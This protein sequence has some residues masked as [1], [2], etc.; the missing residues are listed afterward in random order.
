MHG[1]FKSY[2]QTRQTSEF[3]PQRQRIFYW[4]LNRI[5]TVWKISFN[6][7]TW[8]TCR[9]RPRNEPRKDGT[10]NI[11]LATKVKASIVAIRY[12]S[13]VALWILEDYSWNMNEQYLC[14]KWHWIIGVL[15]LEREQ[16][17]EPNSQ[18]FVLL[19]KSASEMEIIFVQWW[20]IDN[21][22]KIIRNLNFSWQMH[23]LQITGACM[24]QYLL[25]NERERKKRCWKVFLP[26]AP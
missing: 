6:I 2:W 26:S 4:K 25:Q 3:T 23:L 11:E 20:W 7:W 8:R 24:P 18:S 16:Q 14:A 13:G 12:A 19:I 9:E 1:V 5:Q 15:A 10:R 21:H 22:L 17:K